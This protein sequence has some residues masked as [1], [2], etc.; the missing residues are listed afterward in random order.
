MNGWLFDVRDFGAKGDGTTN[1]SP[2]FQAAMEAMGPVTSGQARH[3]TLFVSPGDYLLAD[4]LKIERAIKL[5]GVAP[6]SGHG[7]SRLLFAPYKGIRTYD[8]G[9][10]PRGG[11]ANYAVIEDLDIVCGHPLGS[12]ISAPNHAIWQ[13]NTRY[14]LRDKILPAVDR[15]TRPGS[16]WEYYYECVVKTGTSGDVEPDWTLVQGIDQATEWQPATDYYYS[17]VVRAPEMLV[18]GEPVNRY[19]VYFTPASPSY[20]ITR[21]AT[22][23]LLQGSI[24]S[25]SIIPTPFATAEPGDIVEELNS[26]GQTI[27]WHCYSTGSKPPRWQPERRYK[28]GTIVRSS[29][30]GDALFKLLASGT[31]PDGLSFRTGS[32]EPTVFAT[33]VP[34]PNVDNPTAI[35]E[36]GLDGTLQWGCYFDPTIWRA[37]TNYEKSRL[38]RPVK[39]YDVVFSLENPT[40]VKTGNEEPTAFANAKPGDLINEVGSGEHTLAWRCHSDGAYL[41]GDGRTLSP[42]DRGQGPIW[43]CRVAAAIYAQARITVNRVFIQAALNAGLHVQASAYLSATLQRKRLYR[44]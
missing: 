19:D 10:S 44:L 16:T 25:G 7:K 6:G 38:V 28:P 36:S 21:P 31:T 37:N 33:V 8:V 14:N 27:I 32:A 26:A 15:Q 11:D 18:N 9:C 4:D 5:V 43:A 39:R 34:G 41:V 29:T 30:R 23:D 40:S 42:T 35:D 20:D 24:K 3:G 12:A 1:D 2:A 17:S 22:P 13:R